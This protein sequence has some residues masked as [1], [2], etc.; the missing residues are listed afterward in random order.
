M[1]WRP[2]SAISASRPC[3]RSGRARIR[4]PRRSLPG[5]AAELELLKGEAIH[6]PTMADA[7]GSLPNS[8]NRPPGPASA[9]WTA[10]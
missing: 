3:P 8:W 10:R 4:D 2:V 7:R 6:C 1:P 9:A 5:F